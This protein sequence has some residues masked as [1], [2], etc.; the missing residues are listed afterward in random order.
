MSKTSWQVGETCMM[1][2][3]N[4]KV[5]GT[6]CKA[7]PVDGHT[8][9]VCFVEFTAGGRTCKKWI[10]S[11]RLTMTPETCKARAEA[12]RKG[13]TM[14]KRTRKS[15]EYPPNWSEMAKA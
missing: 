3:K 13:K 9:Q 4:T 5:P 15:P 10:Y 14:T 7:V 12:F 11:T 1:E 8:Y 2:L 6:I